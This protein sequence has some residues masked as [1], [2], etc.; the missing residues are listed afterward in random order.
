MSHGDSATKLPEGFDTVATSDQ[1]L[2]T[3]M[4]CEAIH[5]EQEPTDIKIH[6][7]SLLHADG[8][9]SLDL[10]TAMTHKNRE[11]SV[12]AKTCPFL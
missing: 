4:H 11:L 5:A 7:S 10:G 12:W 3:P 6:N 2:S 9:F 8:F 1:V